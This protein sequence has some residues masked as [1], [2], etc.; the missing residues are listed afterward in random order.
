MPDPSLKFLAK[1]TAMVPDYAAQASGIRCFHGYAFDKTIGPKVEI[2]DPI[3]GASSGQVGN[4]GGFVKQIGVVVEVKPGSLGFSECIRHLRDGDLWPGDEYTAALV[5]QK[6]DKDFGGEHS[7]AAKAA[8]DKSLA[9]QREVGAQPLP[10]PPA[11][12][13]KG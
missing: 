7:D 5:G 1:G 10:P 8:Q 12:P 11:P 6:F 3:T 4:H 2:R 13:K 9:E